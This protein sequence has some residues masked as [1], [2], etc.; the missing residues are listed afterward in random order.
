[1]K[2][3]TLGVIGGMGPAATAVFFKKIVDLTPAGSDQEHIP[4]VIL[5]DVL[6]PDRT[7]YILDPSKPSPLP[8]MLEDVKKLE[9]CGADC[10][11]IPCN[12]SHYF[13]DEISRAA[14]VPV[15]SILDCALEAV[16][17]DGKK[18]KTAVLGTYGTLKSGVYNKAAE[19][20]AAEIYTPDNEICDEVMRLIYEQVKTGKAA[21]ESRFVSVINA[22]INNG[23]D[24]VILGCTE[25]SVIYSA[26]NKKYDYVFDSTELLA[27]ACVKFCCC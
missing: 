20:Y 13:Y 23:C 21:D 19:K 26:M 18:H 5:N 2:K 8:R 27:A 7:S 3:K 25:L 1:M 14:S 6:I 4:A 17:S 24:S 12:T 9:Y 16:C 22:V 15:I 11:A 10:I